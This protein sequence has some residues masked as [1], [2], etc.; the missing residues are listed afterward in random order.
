MLSEIEYYFDAAS[1]LSRGRRERQEDALAIDFAQGT[2]LGFAVLA[3]GMGGHEAGDIASQI[4]VTEVFSEL[5]MWANEP[6][7]LE[8]NI[9]QVFHGA[10]SGANNCVTEFA[11]DNC[12]Q[13]VMGATLIATVL[14]DDRLY[15][16]SVG[17]SPL[18]LF[19]GGTLARL[20]EDHSLSSQID[21]MKGSGLHEPNEGEDQ[22]YSH[23]VTSV[24]AGRVI[25]QIDCTAAP[26]Q[27]CPGDI[28]IAAS[29]GLQFLSDNRIARILE[30]F[31]SQSSAV[32]VSALMHE[33]EMLDDPQQDNVSLCVIKRQ[34]SAA[35]SVM[36]PE[37][38][39]QTMASP[40]PAR[41]DDPETETVFARKQAG[42]STVTICVS[43]KKWMSA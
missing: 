36:P 35:L 14:F 6:D 43:K 12:D 18:Y 15:W 17:D 21:R 34:P 7:R 42:G 26:F 16:I 27:V 23:C 33:L 40:R 19:R 31:K 28:V 3:D 13:D 41:Q 29:D 9:Q 39:T 8:R 22:E 5:K 24:L 38:T 4:V 2:G 37:P 32:I 20:N 10:V 11:R 30:R 1:A 25:P